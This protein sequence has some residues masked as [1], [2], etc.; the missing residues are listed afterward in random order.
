MGYIFLLLCVPGNVW[1]DASK[2][3][4]YIFRCCMFLYFYMYS[5]A[6]FWN[7]VNLLENSLIFLRLTFWVCYAEKTKFRTD[8]SP[9]TNH[10]IDFWVLYVVSHAS[11]GFLIL[12]VVP[13]TISGSMW[14]L[15]IVSPAPFA[16]LSPT[17][18]ASSHTL[19]DRCSVEEHL[20]K[21][22]YIYRIFLIMY[23]RNTT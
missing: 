9:T 17:L 6:L 20:S 2:G 15:R 23:N 8:V 16:C 4:L 1:L 5:S 3:N 13:P 22:Q 11:E 21:L 19:L 12:V 14:A 10:V 18:A 7:I